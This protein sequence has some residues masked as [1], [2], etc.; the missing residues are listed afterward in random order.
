[1]LAFPGQGETDQSFCPDGHRGKLSL[2]P[3]PPPQKKTKF[4]FIVVSPSPNIFRPQ[5]DL[6]GHEHVGRDLF[7]SSCTVNWKINPSTK[8]PER[9]LLWASPFQCTSQWA[10]RDTL[11]SQDKY[12]AARQSFSFNCLAITTLTAGVILNE[13]KNPLLRGRDSLGGI[14]GDNLGEVKNCLETVGRPFLCR[15]TWSRCL[16]EPSGLVCTHCCR[17]LELNTNSFFSQTFRAPPNIL[18]KSR[19]IPPKNLVSLG[20]EGHTKLFG[21]HPLT[22]KTLTPPEDIRTKKFRFGLLFLDWCWP[23]N[24]EN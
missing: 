20:F 7:W 13:E 2:S 19:D 10:L 15:E 1:M 4:V 16:A 6:Q 24:Q 11:M 5:L 3:V 9:G 23:P 8:S 21:P 22:W 18:A 12:I 17:G 14:L